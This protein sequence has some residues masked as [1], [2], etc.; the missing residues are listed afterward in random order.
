[1]R[2][3]RTRVAN[4]GKWYRLI[5]FF[6]LLV[7]LIVMSAGPGTVSILADPIGSNGSIVLAG[8]TAV[9]FSPPALA[10]LKG[11]G[12]LEV[13]VGT[14]D[15][16]V[17]AI[18]YSSTSPFLSVLWSHDTSADLGC[19][20]SIRG[21]I[22]AGDLNGD[23]TVEAVVPVGDINTNTCGGLVVLNG[24]TGSLKW[25]YKSFDDMVNTNGAV[26]QDGLSDP[27]ISTPALGDLDNDGKLEI[28]VGGMDQRIYAFRSDGT[29]MPGWPRFVRDS[30][31]SSSALADLDNDGFLEAIIGV[32]THLEG[33]PFNTQNG[34]ALYVFRQDGT[35]MPGWP[36]FIKES[37]WSSPAVGD[38][39]NDG[40]LEIVHG[41]GEVYGNSTDGYAVY[42]WDRLGNLLW[43]AP[44]TGY[45][46][47]SPALGDVNGD[48]R[49]EV[50]VG[51]KD[52]KLYALNNNG[53]P[54]WIT[55]PTNFQGG[56]APIGS[57]ALA[58][59]NNADALPDAFINVFWDSAILNG[60]NGSQFTANR[61]PGDSK[62]AY[63]GG[64][65]TQDNAPALGDLD[66]DGKLEL[67]LASGNN[68]G[69][70]CGTA[71]VNFWRLTA[72]APTDPANTS[73]VPWPMFGQ[74]ARHTRSYPKRLAF[75][76]EVV[77]HTSPS[78]MLPG[79]Q[80]QVSITLR[81]TGTNAWTSTS[82]IRLG[83]VGDSDPFTTSNRFGLN[84]GESIG[85]NQ[86][87]TFTFN[88]QAPSTEGYSKPIGEW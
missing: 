48:G 37:I 3:T 87:K 43:K 32:D 16:K 53:S 38:L 30:S 54:V 82:L 1:M 61:F 5:G 42:A 70:N 88:L 50:V 66:G 58:T 15:G 27:I 49:L 76:S 6:I 86:T 57:P 45:V 35:L 69:A 75:D 74:N 10:D 26:G 71:Q 9:R 60:S 24:Q 59:Y 28:V 51:A 33:A 7:G 83:A 73:T 65:T 22:S 64:C 81:N 13:L 41:T 21:A 67:V 78:I 56:T 25:S 80:R 2:S 85:L 79:E 63:V 4:N 11:D 18:Q 36:K 17:Y 34:G 84:A 72:S 19:A 29:M 20:T 68:S 31:A 52:N 47:G 39:N 14:S 77:S 23:G 40:N 44:T 12:H 55:T 62:P 8:A 46:F